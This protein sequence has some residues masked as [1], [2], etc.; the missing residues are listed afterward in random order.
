MGQR[1]EA[2]ETRTRE[3]EKR[4]HGKK[5]EAQREKFGKSRIERAHRSEEKTKDQE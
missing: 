1:R 5:W 3:K 4:R 2:Q